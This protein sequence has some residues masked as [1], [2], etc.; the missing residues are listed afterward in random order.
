MSA[1]I[2]ALF[3]RQYECTDPSLGIEYYVFDTVRMG[4]DYQF[5]VEKEGE[6]GK[7]ILN[8]DIFRMISERIPADRELIY[9]SMFGGNAH[10]ALNLLEHPRPFEIIMPSQPDRYLE[11]RELIPYGY[12]QRIIGRLAAPYVLNMMT[13]REAV[14][15][16]VFHLESPPPCGDNDYILEH[17][18]G[19]F[20]SQVETPKIAPRDLR[21]KL[22]KLHSELIRSASEP[23]DIRFV[24]SPV[25]SQDN[26]GFLVPE[27]Y[28]GDST[29]AGPA[30]G[31]MALRHFER[32]LN[33]QYAGWA[34]LY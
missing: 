28:G 23:N 20:R 29:H 14:D 32:M 9:V 8:P 15:Q 31:D 4:G 2:N 27:C 30:Y 7:Y 21:Y 6:P 26:E 16:P 5:S 22:W 25:Q 17:L 24:G 33:V 34:W 18:E 13:L 11:G 1:V 12:M 3:P 19:Y 10:N